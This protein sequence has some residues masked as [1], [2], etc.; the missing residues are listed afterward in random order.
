M[1]RLLPGIYIF[2]SL[3]WIPSKVEGDMGILKDVFIIAQLLCP[4]IMQIYSAIS[5]LCFPMPLLL[6]AIPGKNKQEDY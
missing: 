4:Q 2:F 3:G 5:N 6:L 1:Y